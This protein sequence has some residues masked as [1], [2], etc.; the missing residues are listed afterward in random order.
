MKKIVHITQAL[1][2]VKTHID[3]II[4]NIN[5]AEFELV[6]IAPADDSL[7]EL[8]SANNVKYYKLDFKREASIYKDF[9]CLFQ[10][11]KLLKKEQPDIVHTHSAKGGFLGRLAAKLCGMKVIYTPNGLSYLSFTGFRRVLYY[12][13]EHMAK[14]WT[15]LL[16]A[17]SYSEAN[18]A[19]FELGFN[20]VRVKVILN[21]IDVNGA[22]NAR[23]FGSIK[24]IGM[25]SRLTYQKNPMLFLRIAKKTLLKYPDIK[26]SILGSGVHDHL[27]ENVRAY[28]EENNLSQNIEIVPWGNKDASSNYLDN[29]D[30]FMLTSAFEGLPY[31]LLESM[32]KGVP[33]IVSAADGN[34][35]VIKNGE[36]GFTCMPIDDYCDRIEQLANSP[37]LQQQISINAKNYI[38]E[39]HDITKNIIKL[40]DI[41][42]NLD[43]YSSTI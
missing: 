14:E 29:L 18:R 42:N 8:C 9:K 4:T 24:R 3:H 35:D 21:S 17:V 31:S 33:C 12:H 2:G 11:I 36:N 13:L 28:I 22:V 16:L 40:E 5:K 1:G 19:Y 43:Y 37:Q 20:P 39:H 23:E 6:L 10:I 34:S 38:H 32:L 25:I 41:Y 15:T 30:V 27:A 26:F 7:A